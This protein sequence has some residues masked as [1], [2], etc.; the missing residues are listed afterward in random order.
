MP[1]KKPNVKN[2]WLD[3]YLMNPLSNWFDRWMRRLFGLTRGWQNR[4][5]VEGNNYDLGLRHLRLGNFKDA[6][7]RFRIT[8]WI[9]PKRAE[10]WYHLGCAYIADRNPRKARAALAQAIA[11]KPGYEDALYMRAIAADGPLPASQLP[12][13]TPLV[14]TQSYFD[15]LAE[16]YDEQQLRTLRYRGHTLS[17]EAVAAGIGG[18]PDPVLL[19]LGCGT[20]L[21]GSALVEA[22][23]RAGPATLVG[24]DISAA[25]LD[26]AAALRDNEGRKIYDSLI[27]SDIVPFL[28]EAAEKTY[29]A[30]LACGVVSYMGDIQPLLPAAA[31]ALKPGGV[32]VFTADKLDGQDYRF[33][34]TTARFRYAANYLESQVASAGMRMVKIEEAPVYPDYLMWL[35]VATR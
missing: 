5:N 10:A 19:D 8:T 17:A 12:K 20:G 24:V 32:F 33:D 35:V 14:L 9:N 31:M 27:A 11:L 13:K 21:A 6:I 22:G 28:A 26:K 30:I 34:Q 2:D 18:R 23:L 15:G 25:M 7:L 16:T 3:E 29:D 1:P 4:R